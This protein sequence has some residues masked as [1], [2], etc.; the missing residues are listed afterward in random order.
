MQTAGLTAPRAA[1]RRQ[2]RGR[3]VLGLSL[4]YVAVLT[5]C[6]IQSYRNERAAGAAERIVPLRVALLGTDNPA[7]IGAYRDPD[8]QQSAANARAWALIVTLAYLLGVGTLRGPWPLRLASGNLLMFVFVL[9]GLEAGTHLFGFHFPAIARRGP[10]DRDLW[11][12]D[13]T[14]GWF[15]SPHGAGELFH[16]GPDRGRVRL[17]ALGLRG[18]EVSRLKPDGVARVLVFGDSFV[19]GL[20]VDEENVFTT[21]LERCLDSVTSCRHEV[22]NMG[23]SG[24]STDQELLLL[25]EL[26][27]KL[28]P[29]VVVLVVCDND[30]QGNTED[31]VYR[32]Y[33]KPYFD[34]G[35]GGQISLANSPVPLLSRSQRVKLFLGQESNVWNFVRSR[36]A[37][38][39]SATRL[40]NFLEVGQPRE[41]L[42]DPVEI[43]AALIRAFANRVDA[44]GAKFF[45]INTGH[46]GERTPL[47]HAL[48]PKLRSPGIHQLGLEEMLGNARRDAPA[49]LWD[50]PGDIHWNRDAHRLAA[51][52]VCTYVVKHGLVVSKTANAR[53]AA[54]R[55]AGQGV[56][57]VS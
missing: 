56:R 12:Y 17:N 24:Y 23:V 19:F 29:D 16:G 37:E 54:P 43:T 31:F 53:R 25:E 30:F 40:L 52:I 15:H 48:R 26:G 9:L 27:L 46:R 51:E 44:A 41:S 28:S 49:K 2:P 14:K 32:R 4:L 8:V 1:T 50:F 55:A 11:V 34:L 20:G 35:D 38:S 47:F 6:L 22:I 5:F 57:R 33:Y 42:V 36:K 21:Q 10:S 13:R 45:V 3:P 18:G 7:R 39:P